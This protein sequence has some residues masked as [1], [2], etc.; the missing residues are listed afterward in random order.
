MAA[1]DIILVVNLDAAD[2]PTIVEIVQRRMA[3]VCEFGLYTIN[4]KCPPIVGERKQR[5]TS[6]PCVGLANG[7]LYVCDGFNLFL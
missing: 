7:A 1:W 3:H 4:T 5:I 6:R 2:V